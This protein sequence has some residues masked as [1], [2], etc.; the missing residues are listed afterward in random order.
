MPNFLLPDYVWFPSPGISVA[1][2]ALLAGVWPLIDEWAKKK[3]RKWPRIFYAAV[4]ALLCYVEV[5]SVTRDRQRFEATLDSQDKQFKLTVAKLDDIQKA[6]QVVNTGTVAIHT[7]LSKRG[8]AAMP[9]TTKSLKLEALQFSNDLAG[10]AYER[11]QTEPELVMPPAQAPPFLVSPAAMDNAW[12]ALEREQGKHNNET[13]DLY[14]HFYASHVNEVVQELRIR[15]VFDSKA[16]DAPGPRDVIV[17][18]A[19]IQ[20]AAKKL[21]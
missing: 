5:A 19:Q 20:T 1:F 8:S 10:F 2:L 6:L 4:L 7:E 17:C 15:G 21:P 12:A 14:Q 11:S 18:A 16:C 13:V 3:E 9:Q